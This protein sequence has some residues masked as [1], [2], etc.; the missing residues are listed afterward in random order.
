[1][2]RNVLEQTVSLSQHV[3][4]YKTDGP[5]PLPRFRGSSAAQTSKDTYPSAPIRFFHED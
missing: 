3:N 5:P 2:R 1:M 4:D